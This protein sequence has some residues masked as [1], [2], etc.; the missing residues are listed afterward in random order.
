MIALT[1]VVTIALLILILSSVA[2][3]VYHKYN[4]LRF[5]THQ[6]TSTTTTTITAEEVKDL[7]FELQDHHHHDS[8]IDNDGDEEVEEE[9][10]EELHRL[11][12]VGYQ[13]N[14]NNTINN[15]N[16]QVKLCIAQIVRVYPPGSAS[17]VDIRNSGL[18]NGAW[19][20]IDNLPNSRSVRDVS[21]LPDLLSSAAQAIAF[22]RGSVSDDDGLGKTGKEEEE[23]EEAETEDGGGG[24]GFVFDSSS[25]S[26][27]MK[28]NRKKKR[29]M[30]MQPEENGKGLRRALK[31][32]IS[33]PRFGFQGASVRELVRSIGF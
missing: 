30:V 3:G 29:R 21:T 19:Y 16:Y 12:R 27:G 28:E 25:P 6:K 33:T 4:S 32:R 10:E 26:P 8:E 9:E 20:T 7:P 1:I 11:E 17:M 2:A 15:N 24:G 23:E 5:N 31:K 18:D 14:T 22:T 13:P